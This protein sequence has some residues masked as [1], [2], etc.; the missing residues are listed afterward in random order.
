MWL[1]VVSINQLILN[2]LSKQMHT[3]GLQQLFE[4][5]KPVIYIA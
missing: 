4:A 2:F 5:F 3:A 1:I